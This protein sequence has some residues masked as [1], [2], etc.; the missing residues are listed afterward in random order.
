[1]GAPFSYD[2]I[3]DF[4]YIAVL[5][6]ISITIRRYVPFFSKF[7]IPDAILAGLLGIVAGP[8][9]LKIIPWN[10]DRLAAIVYH[11]MAIGFIAL[12]LKKSEVKDKAKTAF[13]GG[14]FTI[15]SYGIQGFL[16]L[17]ITLIL[18]LTLYPS[19]FPNFG[20]LLPL[21]FAQGPGL[22]GGMGHTWQTLPLPQTLVFAD[23]TMPAG[24]STFPNG[25]SIGFSFSTLGFLWACFVG[26]PL[27]NFLM[28]R[29]ARRGEPSPGL[30]GKPAAM[31]V[32]KERDFEGMSRSVDKASTQIMLVGVVYLGVYFMI[33][34]LTTLLTKAFPGNLA[35]NL[36]SLLWVLVFAFGALVGNLLTKLIDVLEDKGIL[37]K[38]K[39]RS[40]Y[41]LNHIG[42]ISVDFMIAASIAAIDLRVF[43]DYVVPLLIVTT[44]G[45]VATIF[46]TWFFVSKVWPKTFVE[47]FLA[48]F[49]TQTGTVA[50]GMGLLRGV[51][52]EFRTSAAS[53]LV[54]GSGIAVILGLPLLFMPAFLTEGYQMQKHNLYWIT[55]AATAGYT[56]LILLA[57]FIFFKLS[58]RKRKT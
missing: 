56:L 48:F 21:G 44:V 25:T 40:N 33:L 34:G 37:L 11:L 9:V 27:M 32:E 30:E 16:G 14:F 47:H 5:L 57:W 18:I 58:N 4:C 1:M 7:R 19:L 39:T 49:G 17:A 43:A 38:D 35:K 51:D 31:L 52:P 13:S 54:Y 55:L 10:T 28:R 23:K 6:L 45:G 26:V 50:T 2:L 12:S 8:S 24:S 15:A 29:R 3:L 22:A 42:G 36:N 53:D 46:Y 41:I 20:F